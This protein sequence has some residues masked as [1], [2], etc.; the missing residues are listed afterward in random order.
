MKREKGITLIALVITIIVLLILAGV[1]ISLTLGNNGVLNQATNSV[2]KTR[3]AS[4]KEEVEMA[5]AGA[6]SNYWAEWANDSSKQLDED[7]LAEELIG[8]TAN[9]SIEDVSAVGDGTYMLEYQ[10]KDREEPYE[11]S[12]DANGVVTLLDSNQGTVDYATLRSM[13]GTVVSGYTGYTATDVT[14]WKLFYVDEKNKEAFLMASQ[15]VTLPDTKYN[16]VSS[17]SGSED[18]KKMKYAK[19]YNGLWLEKCETTANTSWRRKSN[20]YAM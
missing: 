14:E 3:N 5:W 15:L 10:S 19:R 20:S 16:L 13:Y 17:Y 12:V 1:S 11:F 6:V 8:E 4:A 7:F 9:G 2:T 18:A